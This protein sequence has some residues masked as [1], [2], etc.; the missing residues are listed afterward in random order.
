MKIINSLKLFAVPS[1]PAPASEAAATQTPKRRFGKKL[2]V[3]LAAVAIVIIAAAFFI[4]QGEA[5]IP[6]S[7]DYAVGEKMAYDSTITMSL[8]SNLFGASLQVPNNLT[9]DSQQTIEVVGFDGDN[10]LLNHTTT[11]D[12]LGKPVSFSV[13][14]KMNK[15]GYSTYLFSTGD[16]QTEISTSSLAGDSY[17][18]QLLND[19]QAKVGETFTVPYPSINS[20]I[21]TTGDL[22]VK[23]SAIQDLTVSAGTFRVFRID[24]TSDN[25]QMTINIPQTQSGGISI[26]ASS[27][28]ANLNLNY[29]VYLEYGTMRQIQSNMQETTALQ[30]SAINMTLQM[31]MDM[32]LKQDLKP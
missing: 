21:Q 4:P 23:F 19:P 31:G 28:T 6:L 8:D 2:Y 32:T 20:N 16:T 13:N 10:Y 1:E 3:V 26:P 9:L 24:I 12:V 22:T 27:I 7:V 17:L 14:E 25:L 18:A 30:S 11:M 29:Q 15:T 5:T